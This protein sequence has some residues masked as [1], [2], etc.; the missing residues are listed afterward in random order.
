MIDSMTNEWL[1]SCDQAQYEGVP[2][3]PPEC[4]ARRSVPLARNW[5]EGEA[6]RQAGDGEG[7]SAPVSETQCLKLAS[8]MSRHY[9]S[10]VYLYI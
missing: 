7:S 2:L 3:H 1:R 10:T 9:Q 8:H 4:E 5:M 6:W